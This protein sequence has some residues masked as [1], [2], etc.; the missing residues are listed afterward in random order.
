MI[1]KIKEKV[2]E[3]NAKVNI[4]INQARQSLEQLQEIYLKRSPPRAHKWNT[5]FSSLSRT[6]KTKSYAWLLSVVRLSVRFE[7]NANQ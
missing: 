1:D 7:S 5:L 2:A 4:M 6:L 3:F